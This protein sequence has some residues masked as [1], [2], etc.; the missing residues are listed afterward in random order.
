MSELALLPLNPVLLRRWPSLLAF[1][2]SLFRLITGVSAKGSMILVAP[3]RF[4]GTWSASALGVCT[5][6]DASFRA[7]CC[8]GAGVTC[9]FFAFS[10]GALVGAGFFDFFGAGLAGS[11]LPST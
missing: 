6:A 10:T 9:F 8:S 1:R 2:I 7:D 11:E 4:L 3:S 5:G